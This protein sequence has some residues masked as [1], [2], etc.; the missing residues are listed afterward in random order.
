[1]AEVEI[2]SMLM[3]W[4]ANV[5]NIDAAM[6][7]FDFMPAPM[8]DTRAMSA[9]LETSSGDIEA[10]GLRSGTVRARTGSGD[11]D[12]LFSAA[13]QD[14]DAEAGSGDVSVLV[15]RGGRYAVEAVTG[16]GDRSVGVVSHPRAPA[17]LRARTG[18]GDVSVLYGS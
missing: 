7:G 17:S 4:D 15:P 6:P 8:T 14:V 5:S 10:T 1:M 11:V 18:S 13:P 12:L 2:M 3:A 16:S 9:S